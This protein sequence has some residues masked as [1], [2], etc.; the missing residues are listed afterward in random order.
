MYMQSHIPVKFRGYL[1]SC[2]VAMLWLQVHLSPLKSIL[3]GCYYRPSS[4]NSQYLDNSVVHVMKTEIYVLG[5]RNI[6]F[7]A[8]SCP[9]TITITSVCNLIQVI[10]QSTRVHTNKTGTVSSTCIDH[11]YI[12]AAELYSKAVSIGFG[13]HNSVSISRKTKVPK[14]G[15]KLYIKDDSYAF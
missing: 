1:M 6:N 9:L 3:L 15:S 12:N 7:L 5:D 13:D 8:S 14:A 10:N 2:D 4:S 11:M